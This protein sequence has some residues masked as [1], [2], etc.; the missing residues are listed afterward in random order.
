MKALLIGLLIGYSVCLQANDGVD[1]VIVEIEMKEDVLI[2]KQSIYIT[3]VDEF[4]DFLIRALVIEESQVFIDTIHIDQQPTSF[5]TLDM[6]PTLD[7]KLKVSNENSRIDVYYR[8]NEIGDEITLPL[9]FTSLS[10]LN[11][12]ADFFNASIFRTVDQ[13][14]SVVFP[15]V[16]IEDMETGMFKITSFNLPAAPSMIRLNRVNSDE[17]G[18]NIQWVDWMVGVVFLIIGLILWINRKKM[19]Y[20]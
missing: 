1:S 4:D 13:H 12:E 3:V 7:F 14:F 6:T 15:R 10:A 9:F 19:S 18:K 11:S 17:S 16:P 2:V 5:E 8:L 20:G